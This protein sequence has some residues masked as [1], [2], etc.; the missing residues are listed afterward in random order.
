MHGLARALVQELLSALR[1]QLRL[2]IADDEA[3]GRE[4][5]AFARTVRAHCGGERAGFAT[6]TAGSMGAQKQRRSGEM[7][8]GQRAGQGRRGA[9]LGLREGKKGSCAPPSLL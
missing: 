1:V 3:D 8:P 2:H 5:V 7:A 9:P 6:E 4:E